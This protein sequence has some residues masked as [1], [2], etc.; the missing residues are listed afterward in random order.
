ME[1]FYINLRKCSFGTFRVSFLR[2]II[3]DKGIE[4]NLEK[5]KIISDWPLLTNVH[6]ARSF[7][8]LARFYRSFIRNLFNGPDF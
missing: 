4:A 5:I 8:R 2:F 7:H 6:E 1:Q 3:S